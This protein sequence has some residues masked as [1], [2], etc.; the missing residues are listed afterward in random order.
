MKTGQERL[1]NILS[2][3]TIGLL[4]LQSIISI[5]N[6]ISIRNLVALNQALLSNNITEEEF[7]IV[8]EAYSD[9]EL[10]DTN[11][12]LYQFS[13]L[14]GSPIVLVFSSHDCSACKSL[15]P[16]LAIFPNFTRNSK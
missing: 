9:F 4:I 14:T 15:Y 8:G 11:D 1:S 3:V 13:S 2:A 10:K 7:T 6:L 16:N 5:I 12:Q